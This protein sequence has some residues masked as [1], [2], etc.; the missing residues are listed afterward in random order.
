M[1][2]LLV[3][4]FLHSGEKVTMILIF[5]TFSK[6]CPA[7]SDCKKVTC[8]VLDTKLTEDKNKVSHASWNL[9]H[10]VHF[11]TYLAC[12]RLKQAAQEICDYYGDCFYKIS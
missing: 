1:L 6:V 9:D 10:C 4:I 12:P 7:I 8:N 11:P 5:R 3:M 2:T